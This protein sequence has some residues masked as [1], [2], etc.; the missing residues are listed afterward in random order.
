M[1][2]RKVKG[3]TSSKLSIT[4]N[5][6]SCVQRFNEKSLLLLV[7]GKKRLMNLGAH[8]LQSIG[9]SFAIYE[10]DGELVAEFCH[11]KWAETVCEKIRHSS[12]LKTI[13]KAMRIG[14]PTKIKGEDGLQC[15]AA[16]ILIKGESA[17]GL[18]FLYINKLPKIFNK[19]DGFSEFVLSKAVINAAKEQL[20]FYAQFCGLILEN[21]RASKLLDN[22]I[23]ILD[24]FSKSLRI[25]GKDFRLSV[26]RWLKQV[27]KMIAAAFRGSYPVYVQI[28]YNDSLFHT[29][30]IEKSEVFFE[31]EI[32]LH[33]YGNLSIKISAAPQDVEKGNKTFL[34]EKIQL[35]NEF[36]YLISEI[37]CRKH[38][39][40]ELLEYSERFK[41]VF[42][43]VSDGII[44][45]DLKT[46]RFVFA[47]PLMSKITGYTNSEL[48]Q[49]MK[50]SDIHPTKSVSY[51][52][53]RFKLDSFKKTYANV[54]VLRKD[55]T[56]FFCDL[57]SSII[58][59][60]GEKYLMMFFK[61]ITHRLELENV[62]KMK[63]R[64][65]ITL[66]KI[67]QTLVHSTSEND[68]LHEVCHILVETCEYASAW[69]GF[70]DIKS[71]TLQ[72]QS[73]NSFPSRVFNPISLEKVEQRKVYGPK[74][75]VKAAVHLKKTIVANHLN[76]SSQHQNFSKKLNYLSAI[77]LPL[78]HNNTVYGTLN[79]YS[80]NSDVFN[81]DEV[82]LLEEIAND[83]NFGILSF[84]MLGEKKDVHQAKEKM[85]LKFKKSL[86]D[87]I[88]IMSIATEK[89]DPYTASHQKR[90]SQL[91]VAIAKELNLSR[92]IIEGIYFG[93]LLLGTILL[94]R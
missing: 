5:S 81:E 64:Q 58:K 18:C 4:K 1:I 77:A 23:E 83:L 79:I 50:V 47:N 11:P 66:S 63:N 87:S 8:C 92:E 44:A 25:F 84:R 31:K 19:K 69:I 9:T 43:N 15:Y 33:R 26:K 30:P 24:N 51:I 52:N 89:R 60:A 55:G 45:S 20:Q 7:I 82:R 36:I 91:S 29:K 14:K 57:R 48:M 32:D 75:L 2:N 28:V 80:K 71:N 22:E 42:E 34:K 35:I 41:S 88:S 74:E 62:L 39:E 56:I 94:S 17:G 21:H 90:V 16:P 86:E 3:K 53:H 67:N 61:D 13:E 65:I 59:I 93:S 73:H 54:P 38:L 10:L 37:L 72:L 40:R 68:L 46:S 85:Y 6:E 78:M 49:G 76:N 27:V 70:V 12:C